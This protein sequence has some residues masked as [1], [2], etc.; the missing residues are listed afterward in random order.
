MTYQEVIDYLYNA[1]PMFQNIGAGAYKEGLS[2]TRALDEHFGHP[3]ASYRTIH[4]A[5]TNGK[6]SVSSTLAALLQCAGLRV[7]LYTSPHLLDFRERIR[8]NGEMIPEERVVAFVE[9]ERDFFEPLSPS[10]FELTTALAFLYF[11]EQ[12]VDV[13]VVEVGL[14]GRLDCTNI[15]SP[16]LSII[17]NISFD[18]T[19]FL[20]D[21][22]AQ[23]A[24]EKAGIMKAGVPVVV[25][26]CREQ[27]E[28][29]Q[30][31]R[32][33]AARVGAPLY[34]ADAL[35]E[36]YRAQCE[37]LAEITVLQGLY[38]KKNLNTVLCAVEVLQ[39][40]DFYVSLS[41]AFERACKEVCA[42]TGFR[43]RW[44]CIAAAPR[45]ICDVG[46]NVAGIAYVARQLKEENYKTL[47][48][49]FGMV[50]DKDY[51]AALELLP[52]E[53]VY[54]ITKPSCHR[55]LSE[56]ILAEAAVKTGHKVV[57]N[58][59]SS[60]LSQPFST[61][62]KA[63]IAALADADAEDLIFIGGSCYLVADLMELLAKDPLFFSK[64]GNNCGL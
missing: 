26:E 49:V 35:Q 19:Q 60:N 25:G 13:A 5:G 45:V 20:G 40:D 50:G 28:V 59:N 51:Q 12:K 39:K 33:T 6:G 46:H 16:D 4:V 63:C 38:Q 27:P 44:Q 62:R 32:E 9:Q 7:G 15:I 30:V 52:K 17:T 57:L 1:A 21:T 54:Y 42:L 61:L 14:G 43:G 18:H 11:K 41:G 48:I 29:E 2:T 58:E 47:R 36:K 8:V 22:L 3:H 10:F 34:L 55:A 64:N 37:H 31:M 24:T 56:N 53:A 23:I